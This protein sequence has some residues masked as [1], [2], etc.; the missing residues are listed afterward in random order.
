MADAEDLKSN[1]P[2]VL[3]RAHGYSTRY[4]A[5]LARRTKKI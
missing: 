5:N 4:K 2:R 3:R 1:A